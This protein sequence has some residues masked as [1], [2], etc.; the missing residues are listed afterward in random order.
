MSKKNDVQQN[1]IVV[2]NE[3]NTNVVPYIFSLDRID[4]PNCNLCQCDF[5]DEAEELY[6]NQKRKNYSAIKRMLKD[7]HDYESTVGGIKNHMLYHYKAMK[8]NASN[9]ELVIAFGQVEI[10]SIVDLMLRSG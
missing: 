1:S 8:N 10:Q 4:K 2:T 7:D 5:R 9:Q 6:D 3:T